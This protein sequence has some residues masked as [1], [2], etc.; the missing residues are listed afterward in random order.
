MQQRAAGRVQARQ[1]AH[2]V[3]QLAVRRH[4]ERLRQEGRAHALADV[5][6]HALAVV[7][8]VSAVYVYSVNT[9]NL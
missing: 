7:Q 3:R 1:R 6:Y 5:H 9:K 8:Q 2:L 4:A